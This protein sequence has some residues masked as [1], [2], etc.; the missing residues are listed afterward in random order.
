[1][2]WSPDGKRVA[3]GGQDKT[4]RLWDAETGECKKVMEGHTGLVWSVAWSP[5]GKRVVS[6][7]WD[8]TVR[9]W[10][11]ENGEC[12]KVMEGHTRVVSSVAWSPDGKWVASGSR[13]KTV[14]VWDA[15]S[16]D[17]VDELKGHTGGVDTVAF[18]GVK[19]YASALT[20]RKSL[21]EYLNALRSMWALR[22]NKKFAKVV[23]AK[24][25]TFL[26]PATTLTLASGSFDENIRLWDIKIKK[27]KK[28]RERERRGGGGGRG[29]K[30][31]GKRQD[32]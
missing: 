23:L 29:D 30:E 6:A 4:V 24:I 26:L 16:A 3:S 13:D 21:E 19:T 1:M 25:K 7:S 32:R 28:K 2:A 17:Y 8:K 10:D 18:R 20:S 31:R 22:Q 11:A 5:D 27:T 9:L 15:E 12:E 14:R